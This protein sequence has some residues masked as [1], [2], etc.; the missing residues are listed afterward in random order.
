MRDVMKTI[1]TKTYQQL[2]TSLVLH[3]KAAGLSQYELAK[4]LGEPQSYIAKIERHERRVDVI[5][6]LYIAK[7]LNINLCDLIESL[8]S[9]LSEQEEHP[10]S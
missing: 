1:H 7:V 3:R 4:A 10:K 8:Q 2:C 5:E 6:L 9:A